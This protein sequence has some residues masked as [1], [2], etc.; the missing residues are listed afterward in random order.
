MKPTSLWCI[1]ECYEIGTKEN[2]IIEINVNN[3]L[4]FLIVFNLNDFEYN[5]FL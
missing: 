1:F 4:S 5:L 2:T 3:T